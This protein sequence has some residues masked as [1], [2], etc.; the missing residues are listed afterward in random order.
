MAIPYVH[1]PCHIYVATGREII[2]STPPEDPPGFPNL[3]SLAPD[4]IEGWSQE[5]IAYLGTCERAPVIRITPHYRPIHS[6]RY[7][8]YVPVDHAFIMEEASVSGVLNVWNESVY[9]RLTIRP[10]TVGEF[11]ER[12]Q[13]F[14]YDTGTMMLA[15][16]V[17][18][19]LWLQFPYYSKD[20]GT[21][22]TSPQGYHFYGAWL[23]GPDDIFS[24]TKAARRAVQ[25]YAA[26]VYDPSDGSSYLYDHD[27]TLIPD[28][29]PTASDGVI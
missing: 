21:E 20:F 8:Q 18:F 13:F 6:S 17:A 9:E 15:D 16:G 29:P 3:D 4:L 7:G 11:V 24:G 12:G 5:D 25:F 23:M 27:F 19:G 2:G 10:K 1:G 28:I 26:P 22:F 14:S